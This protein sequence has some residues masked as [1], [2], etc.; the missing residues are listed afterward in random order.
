MDMMMKIK[1]PVTAGSQS[2]ALQPVASQ[3][4]EFFQ[5]TLM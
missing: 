3:I 5:C 2:L 4:I 1:I